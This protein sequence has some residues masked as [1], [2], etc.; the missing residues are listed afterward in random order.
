MLIITPKFQPIPN[1]Y[2][3]IL[4]SYICIPNNYIPIPNYDILIPNYYTPF[5]TI[6]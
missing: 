3:C 1:Y 6:T 2:I 4:I 5:Q